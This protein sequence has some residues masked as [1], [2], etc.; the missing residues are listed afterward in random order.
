MS[1]LRIVTLNTWKCDGDYARRVVLMADGLRELNA[2]IICLQECFAGGGVNT[3]ARLA[4]TLGLRA[5]LA[6]ARRKART[7][8]ARRVISTS[9]LA[10]LTRG[11]AR[12]VDVCA[13]IADPRDGQRIA[14][15]LDLEHD[16][17]PL[18]ISTN[19]MGAST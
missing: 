16:G 9:G 15:R 2:D 19:G 11:V 17:A 10:I 13:L 3:A 14:Q 8:G 12:A 7:F 4:A 18:R 6:P 5:H 1:T